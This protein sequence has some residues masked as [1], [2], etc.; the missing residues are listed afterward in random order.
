MN[1]SVFEY[2]DNVDIWDGFK[3]GIS[4]NELGNI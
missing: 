3:T 2:F 1:N 4:T